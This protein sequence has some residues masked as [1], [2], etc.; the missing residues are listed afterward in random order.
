MKFINYILESQEGD[1]VEYTD[2]KNSEKKILNLMLK[3]EVIPGIIDVSEFLKEVLLIDDLETIYRIV[4][5]YVLNHSEAKQ[6][7][8]GFSDL[9]KVKLHSETKYQYSSYHRLL[10]DYSGVPLLF[11]WEEFGGDIGDKTD[12]YLPEFSVF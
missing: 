9:E 8:K 5:I 4:P 10:S 3:K 6:N 11:V 1:K 2:L 7:E 12:T